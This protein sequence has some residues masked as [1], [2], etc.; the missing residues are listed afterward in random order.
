MVQIIVSCHPIGEF[1]P[2]SR[3]EDSP[4][5]IDCNLTL[6]QSVGFLP[7]TLLPFPLLTLASDVLTRIW[8]QGRGNMD[9]SEIPLDDPETCDLLL[10]GDIDGIDI[11]SFAEL[12]E[13]RNQLRFFRPLDYSILGLCG[14]RNPCMRR[15]VQ[16]AR[17]PKIHRIDFL[18]RTL[19]ESKGVLV[20]HEQ[21]VRIVHHYCGVSIR[22]A[23]LFIRKN[24]FLTNNADE[25]QEWFCDHCSQNGID[26]YTARKT[27]QL[28]C[29]DAQCTMHKCGAA[30]IGEIIY[31]I[32]YL[33]KHFPAEFK[34]AILD[35]NAFSQ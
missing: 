4:A 3:R 5:T 7:F 21:T 31:R 19:S 35:R 32:A 30:S 1:L 18:D 16:R 20:F 27:F 6:A 25:T 2:I 24:H 23:N 33:K 11:E 14:G 15:V 34:E 17:H 9:F 22:D 13:I 12:S 29:H 10:R 8:L 26:K 28:I